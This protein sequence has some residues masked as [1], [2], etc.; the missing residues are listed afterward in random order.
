MRNKTVHT[1]T[2][3]RVI[4]GDDLHKYARR[5]ARRWLR[6]NNYKD[7]ADE[8]DTYGCFDIN[9]YVEDDIITITAYTLVHDDKHN[10]VADTSDYINLVQLNFQGRNK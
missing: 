6:K 3:G 5:W 4:I 7:Y 8:W 1:T 10:V 9:L 2:G